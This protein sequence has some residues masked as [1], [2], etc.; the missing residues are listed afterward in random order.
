MKLMAISASNSRASINRSLVSYA[1]DRLRGILEINPDID[2]PDLNEFEM[3]LYS[4]DRE[5]ET[6]IPLPAHDFFNR[7]GSSDALLVSFAEHNGSVTAAWKNLFDWMSRVDTNVWQG[8]PLAM[9][10][11][12]PGPRAGA[13]VLG[14]QAMLAPH[15]GAK[16]VGKLGIGNWTTSWDAQMKKLTQNPHIDAL[17]QLLSKLVSAA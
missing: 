17:D 10:A 13:G 1:T 6:G 11:A 15:F 3:P 16:V 8:K 12:T 7:I 4:I 5:N 9:L 2:V 14:N